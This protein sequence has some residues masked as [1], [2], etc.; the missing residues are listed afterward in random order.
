[1]FSSIVVL[2]STYGWKFKN[3]VN[4][5]VEM[6]SIDKPRLHRIPPDPIPPVQ[7]SKGSS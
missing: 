2:E 5:K 4:I 1:M 6:Q 3:Q 7:P